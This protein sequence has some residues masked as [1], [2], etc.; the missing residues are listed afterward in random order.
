MS[1]LES[2][3]RGGAITL[4]ILLVILLVRDA[5]RVP[6]ARFAVLYAIGVAAYM[7]VSASAFVNQ[8]AWW[9]FPLRMLG[10]GNPVIFWLLA[11]T[12]FDD[13]F[14]AR[15]RHLVAWIG[16]VC[17]GTFC[18]YSDGRIVH[19][20]ATALSLFFNFVAIWYAVVGKSED[21]VELPAA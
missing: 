18:L 19:A 6:V 14:V 2:V 10:A 15:P 11:A 16:M 20:G 21:L 8:P 1:N 13:E 17:L 3:L 12:L 7:V 4:L 9:L 5:R